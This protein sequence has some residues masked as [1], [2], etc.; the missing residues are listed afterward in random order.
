MP[1]SADTPLVIDPKPAVKSRTLEHLWAS[2]IILSMPDASSGIARV[3]FGYYDP[4]TG[5]VVHRQ[6]L[7]EELYIDD[8]PSAVS[9]VPEAAAAMAAIIEAIPALR[10]WQQAKDQPD[11]IEDPIV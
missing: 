3:N 1:I 4:A 10:E 7:D 2:K 6:D 11:P 9:E 5:E 8:L